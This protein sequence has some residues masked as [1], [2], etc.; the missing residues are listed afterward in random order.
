VAKSTATCDTVRMLGNTEFYGVL[1]LRP[2]RRCLPFHEQAAY[3][4]SGH[5]AAQLTDFF[6]PF[7]A[8][9]TEEVAA[10]A[11][12]YYRLTLREKPAAFF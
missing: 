6:D 10:A 3:Q 12:G 9:S 1:G 4:N 5:Q 7:L 8:Q 11:L 2:G